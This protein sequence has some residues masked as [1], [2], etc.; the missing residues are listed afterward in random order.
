MLCLKMEEQFSVRGDRELAKRTEGAPR[1]AP[2]E[3]VF[4]PSSGQRGGKQGV[5][6][7]S[8]LRLLEQ[9]GKCLIMLLL[10]SVSRGANRA[11]RKCHDIMGAI[12]IE[13]FVCFFNIIKNIHFKC[14]TKAAVTLKKVLVIFRLKTH[15]LNQILLILQRAPS[16]SS[17]T[18]QTILVRI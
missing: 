12:Y 10:V 17:L 7:G 1:G 11:Q 6:R 5:G 18:V 3:L 2:V 15:S 14:W 13:I 8:L 4:G 16:Y 9:R